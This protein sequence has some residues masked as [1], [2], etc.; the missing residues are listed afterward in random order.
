MA[1]LTERQIVNY[2]K[3]VAPKEMAQETF[4][5]LKS[6]IEIFKTEIKKITKEFELV[7]FLGKKQKIIIK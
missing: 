5:N 3:K 4:N 6:Q 7:G 2:I 1:G